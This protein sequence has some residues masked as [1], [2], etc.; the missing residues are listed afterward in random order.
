MSAQF[1]V[2]QVVW[3]S[4]NSAFV[5]IVEIFSDDVQVNWIRTSGIAS[6][7]LPFKSVRKLTARERGR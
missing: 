6:Y 7:H 4:L 2:G 5:Q 3:D 1:Y